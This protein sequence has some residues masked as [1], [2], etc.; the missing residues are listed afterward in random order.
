MP[1]SSKWDRG[2]SEFVSLQLWEALL[3]DWGA[4]HLVQCAS[5]PHLQKRH[6]SD[7]GSEDTSMTEQVQHY[8]G[9]VPNVPTTILSCFSILV[10]PQKCK[11]RD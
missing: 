9:E 10:P 3:C 8:S 11:A 7:H 5:I 4:N 1:K 2:L 6:S